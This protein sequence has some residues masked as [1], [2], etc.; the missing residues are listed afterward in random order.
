MTDTLTLKMT[1]TR[2]YDM[3]LAIGLSAKV[4]LIR[5]NARSERWQVHR[6]L[7]RAKTAAQECDIFWLGRIAVIHY[8]NTLL[9]L[10][11][12]QIVP[13][14]INLTARFDGFAHLEANGFRSEFDSPVRRPTPLAHPKH[15]PRV[16]SVLV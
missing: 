11:D 13:I 10:I 6:L 14:H 2:T 15:L 12:K 4:L 1:L 9:G 5:H 16:A 3:W 8:M 7:R